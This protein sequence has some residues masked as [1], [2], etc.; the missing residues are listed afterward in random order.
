M[1]LIMR[2]IERG[3]NMMKAKD[4]R[5]KTD[6]WEKL[7]PWSDNRI[8][9]NHQF[10]HQGIDWYIKKNRIFWSHLAKKKMGRCTTLLHFS[11]AM[12]PYYFLSIVNNKWSTQ[13]NSMQVRKRIMRLI[14][15][16]IY[17]LYVYHLRFR[18]K[19]S[20]QMKYWSLVIIHWNSYKY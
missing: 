17:I 18:K 13:R 14:D 2:Q 3:Y 19:D 9:H 11:L 1:L 12:E 10:F 16:F 6:R 4:T 5:N 15:D 7:L 8:W 20:V